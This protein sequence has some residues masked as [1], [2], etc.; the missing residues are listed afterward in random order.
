VLAGGGIAGGQVFG[1][2]SAD[3]MNIEEEP[4]GVTH[5]LATLCAALGVSPD[6]ENT[7]NTGRPIKLVSGDDGYPIDKLLA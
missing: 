1:R 7:S 3:G 6:T 5:V 2:T 4:I